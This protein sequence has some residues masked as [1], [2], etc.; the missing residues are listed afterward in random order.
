MKKIII[1]S[2]LALTAWSASRADGIVTTSIPDGAVGIS[3]SA[4]IEFS[5]G[6]LSLGWSLGTS[7]PPGLS[8]SS[9][10]KTATISGTPTTAGTYRIVI[11]YLDFLLRSYTAE[12]NI[13]IYEGYQWRAPYIYDADY[14]GELGKYYGNMNVRI[15]SYLPATVEL[16]GS[17]PPGLTLTFLGRSGS[18]YIYHI[19]YISGTPTATGD[20]PF[21]IKATNAAGTATKDWVFTIIPPQPPVFTFWGDWFWEEQ[22]FL[23]KD[24][25][26]TIPQDEPFVIGY[27]D[28]PAT[29]FSV[30]GLPE[31]LNM[32]CVFDEGAGLGRVFLYGA[33]T[34]A[35]AGE[36]PVTMQFTNENGVNEY[37]FTIVVI[38]PDDYVITDA[39]P[40]AVLGE[41]YEAYLPDV[42]EIIDS[43]DF[44]VWLNWI[45]DLPPG[46][47]FDGEET[48][49]GIPETAGTFDVLLYFT[50]HFKENDNE[51]PIWKHLTLTVI[52]PNA[53]ALDI[54]R[55]EL[56]F[57]SDG[58]W[59]FVEL[60][61]NNTGWVV[62]YFED[63][64]EV[65]TV[66]DE[67]NAV[68]EIYVAPN[69]SNV[70]REAYV[71]IATGDP[72]LD[73][74]IRITQD[75]S[76]ITYYTLTVENGTGSG[77]YE[78][79]AVI[80][81]AADEAP[82]GMMFSLWTGDVEGVED[83]H[84]ANTFYYM[85]ASD[86]HLKALYA[87]LPSDDATLSSLSVEG[88]DITPDFNPTQTYYT[89][90]VGNEVTSIIVH[91]TANDANASV[92]I[93]GADNLK[94]GV[95]AVVVT[96]TAADG[97][98]LTYIISIFREDVADGLEIADIAGIAVWT[99]D[100][101]L[102]VKARQTIE[103]VKI[104]DLAGRLVY[105]EFT[106]SME[107]K[108]SRLSPKQALVLSVKLG[109]GSLVRRKIVL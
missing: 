21:S 105:Q 67:N 86:A 50:I 89:A 49:T 41:Q 91:A 35:V 96:V 2:I 56:H 85:G 83:I 64:V 44:V 27:V 90:T 84:A 18:N 54:S 106:G 32:E 66:G 25:T 45:E 11:K 79:G 31:G 108:I 73:K 43:E 36:F 3:Y 16:I 101:I 7:L 75:A 109:D 28:R 53:P 22:L 78:E 8:L 104:H 107:T 68:L 74:I 71:D 76:P 103:S 61:A 98:V 19:Y 62:N 65:N 4:K 5:G 38:D 60:T 99:Q 52:D 10:G 1:L 94:V 102:Y 70:E 17:L 37:P 63:W 97:S 81:I 23:M 80:E 24:E 87:Q 95:N 13:T 100:G 77:S 26:L 20:Y 40:P 39:L 9:S 59:E 48:I 88:V 29:S 12:Y 14:I 55:D 51:I 15:S 69:A 30:S 57:P 6:T 34:P 58:G 72:E 92:I 82:D 93:V 46:L 47:S 42:I 33:Y